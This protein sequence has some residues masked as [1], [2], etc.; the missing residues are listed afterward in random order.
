M[1]KFIVTGSILLF[2][3]IVVITFIYF[4]PQINQGGNDSH[5]PP[6]QESITQAPPQKDTEE[7]PDAEAEELRA[8]R[9]ALL[10]EADFML[11]GY[12][13]QEAI[14]LLNADE[15]LIN[16]ETRDLEARILEAKDSLVL[17]EGQV[18]HIFF[19][20]LILYPELLFPDLSNPTGGYRESFIYQTEFIK[21]LPQLLEHGWVLYNINDVF[22]VGEDGHMERREIWLPPGRRPLILSID[23]PTYHYSRGFANR[24]L[25][26]EDGILKTEVITPDGETILT[27]DGDIQ[28]ILNDFIREHPE[29]S[30]RGHRGIIAATGFMGIFGYDLQTEESRAEAIKVAE[31]LKETGWLFANH[32][33]THSR[34]PGW[35]APDASVAN[36]RSDVERWRKKIEPIIG[37]TNI[38]IAPFGFVLP[39]HAMEVILDNGFNI[40]CN[41]DFNQPA[42][43]RQRYV[44]QGRIE[45]GGFSMRSQRWAAYITEHFFDVESVL[46]ARIA[47]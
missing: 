18:K 46:D 12:F 8:R 32:S 35:W 29:F 43:V 15:T 39:P 30:W 2:A 11:R 19:H 20:S 10:E 7:C 23:D 45:I 42:F 6:P 13:Y 47:R 21:M 44:L 41:V 3:V 14:E 28:L 34:R 33:F 5:A 17:F 1:K 38:L 31:Y 37:E 25:V 26:D 16:D 9:T 27:N 24:L 36:I 40:Y 22:R 4:I